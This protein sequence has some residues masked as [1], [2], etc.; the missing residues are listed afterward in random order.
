MSNANTSKRIVVRRTR[1]RSK[2]GHHGGAWKIAYADYVTAM[3]AFFLVMWLL[4]LVPREDLTSIAQYFRMP[5]KV[6]IHGGPKIDYSERAV[7]GGS[8][9]P[10][11]NISALTQQRAPTQK[12]GGSTE[13]RKRLQ[14]FKRDL[15]NLIRIDPVLHEFRPQLLLDITNEGL[16]IQIVD[17]Q[18][19]P[20][21][22]TGSAQMQPYMRDILRALAPA[23]NRMPY[24]MTIT[25]HTDSVQY[26]T[27]ERHYSNW[28][29]SADR[30]NAARKELVHG[31]M[32][33]A[34]VKQVLGLSSTVPLVKGDPLAA[35]NRRISIVVLDRQAERYIDEQNAVG[36]VAEDAEL[37]QTTPNT[38]PQTDDPGAAP[39]APSADTGQNRQEQT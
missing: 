25:G 21:F 15:E 29:L 17:A 9:S 39:T 33:E 10:I 26:A 30:A 35:V 3:M 11:P 14:S 28:E 32:E 6:A 5:L 24:R 13:D 18:N 1:S 7:P 34:K 23:F 38:E 31:G 22:A 19:R 37:Q 4:S 16:R 27:G 2:A 36:Q 8:P 12:I 20:M